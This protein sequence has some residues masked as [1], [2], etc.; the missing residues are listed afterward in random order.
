MLAHRRS[1]RRRP[2]RARPRADASARAGSARTIMHVGARAFAVGDRVVTTRNDRR[3]GVVN[4]Q[5]GVS[6]RSRDGPLQSP[7]RRRPP[8]RRCPSATPATVTSTT[9]TRSPPTAPKAPPSTAPSCSAPTSSTASGAT[10][11]CR[12]TATTRAS[13]SR[14]PRRSSTRRRPRSSPGEDVAFRVARMLETSRAQAA[15]LRRRAGRSQRELVERA[16]AA[17]PMCGSP[18]SSNSERG[19]RGTGAAAAPSSIG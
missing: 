13:T 1:R 18:D 4:G 5:T 2:Q 12:A 6:P 17:R 14:P 9:A 11:R 10:P 7:P 19:R 8:A 3:L 16:T 15:R